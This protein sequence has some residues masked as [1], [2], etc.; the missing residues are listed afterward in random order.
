MKTHSFCPNCFQ[1][2]TFDG[3]LC[4]S[5]G[6]VHQQRDKYALAPGTRLN[7]RYLLGRVLGIGGFGITYL[8]CDQANNK[9]CAVKE[10][11]PRAWAIRDSMTNQLIPNSE[12]RNAVY[13][14][15][16]QVFIN[17]AKILQGLYYN[18]NVVNVQNFFYANSTA[19]IVMEYIQGETVSKYMKKLGHTVPLWMATKMLR[20]VGESLSQIHQ[21]M[22]LHRD[23]SPDNIMI[24]PDGEFKLID[25]GA[26]RTY[27]LSNPL[28]MSV[29]VKP[30]F[31]PIEQYSRN[32]RQGPWT[33]IYALAATYYFVVTGKKPPSAPD[34]QTGAKLVP[35]HNLNQNVSWTM[36]NAIQ[37]GLRRNYA[38]RPQTM[39]D[40]LR[41]TGI[42]D[43]ANTN[44]A[45]Q[46]EK[47]C[48]KLQLKQGITV[49]KWYFPDHPMVIG[50]KDG[51]EVCDI[52]LNN[53]QISSKHCMVM[54]DKAGER[55]F[56][57]N[58]SKNHTFVKSAILEQGQSAFLKPGEW[59]Y[60]QTTQERFIFYVEVS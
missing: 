59:F 28:S 21:N 60:M 18:P 22:L 1:V 53:S 51:N 4:N 29:L 11:F 26:T 32:G 45:A 15:G 36:S 24:T 43:S 46:G 16:C 10:Y 31:A 47:P 34:R 49:G 8:A 23:I 50:R 12:G 27:A 42:Y 6:Y 20:Q 13:E 38:E 55:F 52:Y 30:G 44:E 5:C 58:F 33:D 14:H 37:H 41:E 35:L 54:Y 25:F 56:V 7:Q 48:L 17:E 39:A 3:Q 9:L 57:T 19:Y 40:F 2:G